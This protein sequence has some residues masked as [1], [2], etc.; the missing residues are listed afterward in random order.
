MRRLL[1]TLL[2]CAPAML[3]AQPDPG[4]YPTIETATPA[5]YAPIPPAPD[6]RPRDQ[7]GWYAQ[8]YG[9]SDAEADR[10][11]RMQHEISE[12]VGRIR[13]R[14]ETEQRGNY[15]DIW[16]EHT[17]EFRMVVG[18]KRAPA[19]TLRRYTSHPLF[20][21]RQVR[22]SLAELEAAQEDMFAQLRRLG[23]P[24][25]GGTYVTDNEVRI[26]AAVDQREVDALIS[27]GRLRV[28]PA[29]K[30]TGRD[31]LVPAEAVTADARRFVRLLPQ[32]RYRTGAETSELNVGTIV[33]SDGCFRFDR[34]GGDDPFAYFGAETGVRLDGE[35]ALTFY[36]RGAGGYDGDPVRVGERMVLGG[37][38]GREIDDPEIV[39]AVRAACGPG[40]IVYVGNPRSYAAFRARHSAW[41]LD[42]IARH[43][44]VSREEAWA[45]LTAC[46]AR[47]DAASDRARRQPSALA[48][49]QELPVPP[50]EVV[51][52]PPPPPAPP[53]P[54]RR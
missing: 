18:F 49:G 8:T 12:E 3:V 42:E 4:T 1:V 32:T 10:R 37:G 29:V 41:R 11:M 39:S 14:L 30:L 24:A 45:W 46:W 34:P 52:P 20:T 25:E 28:S 38:A 7:R 6:V 36:Q 27:S 16:M 21:A 51:P 15:A 13:R 40:R 44:G 19:A 5:S 43:R 33:L 47:E 26:T 23:I 22:F 17:P 50:C 35:G 2:A 54:A 53:A 48:A 9:V 31:A